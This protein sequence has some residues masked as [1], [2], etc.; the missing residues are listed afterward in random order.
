MPDVP[1][2]YVIMDEWNA[3]WDTIY[4]FSAVSSS[5]LSLTTTT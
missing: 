5:L 3:D 2:A 1:P 4:P